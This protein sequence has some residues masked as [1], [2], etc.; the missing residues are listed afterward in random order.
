MA[1]RDS[2]TKKDVARSDEVS[3]HPHQRPGL[4]PFE[5]IIEFVEG[6]LSG[7]RGLAVWNGRVAVHR[8][9]GP[10]IPEFLMSSGALPRKKWA[11]VA[12]FAAGAN[13]PNEQDVG[14]F[15]REARKSAQD[16]EPAVRVGDGYFMML[17]S[18]QQAKRPGTA[19]IDHLRECA[20]SS[21]TERV[22]EPDKIAARQAV[23]D[24]A[25]ESFTRRNPDAMSVVEQFT[26]EFES[27]RN[28]ARARLQ[29][30]L[31][32]LAANPPTFDSADEKAV[33]ASLLTNL[34]NELGLRVR[35]PRQGC[36]NAAT[37]RAG[38]YG[39][40]KHGTFQLVHGGKQRNKIHL[41]ST[42]LPA[43]E[44]MNAPPPASRKILPDK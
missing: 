22:T 29:A 37:L 32:E 43:L 20:R 34:L 11:W 4:H 41:N 31:D 25:R 3:K 5:A 12:A 21:H 10:T 40:A 17:I 6:E 28:D 36:G 18:E 23:L 1:K 35:C 13:V 26:R 27:F 14:A 19:V 16:S 9:E 8:V 44:L 2:T 38:A 33:F 24:L 15:L 30:A 39:T 42:A 7:R